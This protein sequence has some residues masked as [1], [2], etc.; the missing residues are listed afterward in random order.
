MKKITKALIICTVLLFILVSSSSAMLKPGPKNKSF[1]GKLSSM[2]VLKDRYKLVIGKRIMF[3][4]ISNDS[5][6]KEMITTA[7]SLID[8]MITVTYTKGSNIIL[9]L[10]NSASKTFH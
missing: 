5:H 2:N 10:N 7:K 9:S 4:V 8:K 1:R 3:I 6:T